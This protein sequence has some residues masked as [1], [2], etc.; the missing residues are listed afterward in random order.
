MIRIQ[1]DKFVFETIGISI[2]IIDGF[3]AGDEM[4][5]DETLSFMPVEK[6]CIITF[7]AESTYNVDG[8]IGLNQ[9][10]KEQKKNISIINEQ[11]S[12]IEI[13]GLKGYCATFFLWTRQVYEIHFDAIKNNENSLVVTVSIDCS[14]VNEDDEWYNMSNEERCDKAYEKL[15]KIL[16]RNNIKDYI[17]GIQ[18]DD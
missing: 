18:I 12:K 11:P 17:N 4:T 16:E 13:N 2:P 15:K 7:S 8:E 1:K 10:L 6:D 5:G 3:F 14:C 9:K